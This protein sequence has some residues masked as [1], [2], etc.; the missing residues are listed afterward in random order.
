MKFSAVILAGGQSSRMGRDKAWLAVG[1]QPLLARQIAL[2]RELRPVE[3]FLSGRDGVDY[4][5]FGCPVLRDRVPG[6]GPLAG[7]LAGLEAATSPLVLVLA[8]DLPRMTRAVLERV[9]AAGGPECGIVP[10]LGRELEPLAAV[11]PRAAAALAAAQLGARRLAV[12]DFAARCEQL[13]LVR[14]LELPAELGG[15]F[16]NVNS[17]A[18]LAALPV[19]PHLASSQGAGERSGACCRA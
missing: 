18:D 16:A 2:V 13:C 12:R 7:I 5:A 9:C 1:G 3:V 17:P 4:S 14:F 19:P 11:Y 8:V 6:C 15:C 10:R